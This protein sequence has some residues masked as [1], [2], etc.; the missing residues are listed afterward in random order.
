MHPICAEEDVAASIRAQLCQQL[1]FPPVVMAL[2]AVALISVAPAVVA[3]AVPNADT[4]REAAQPLLLCFATGGMLGDVFLHI[5]P[6]TLGGHSHEHGEHHD[7]HDHGHDHGHDDHH[8]DEHAGH[9]HS[10]ADASG[11]LAVLGGFIAFFLVEKLV[12]HFNVQGGHTHGHGHS[13]EHGAV[14]PAAPAPAGRSKSPKRA[15]PGASTQPR[16]R[17]GKKEEHDHGHG[18][19]VCQSA[20]RTQTSR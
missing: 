6:E 11:S 20:A 7:G 17:K 16:R 10:F 8:H 18:H 1:A 13:H 15:S 5:L 14:E 19:G 4:T 3:M 9:D 12:R 2:G